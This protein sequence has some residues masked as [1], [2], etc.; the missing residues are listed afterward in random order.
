MTIPVK[1][2][3]LGIDYGSVRL[4]IAVSDPL[5]IIAR[6]VTVLDNSPHLISEIKKLVEELEVDTIVVGF[7]YTLSGTTGKK[8]VE[9]ESFIALLRAQLACPVIT[10]DERFSSK[11]A[12]DTLR[13]MGVAKKKRQRKGTIDEM[14]AALILQSYLDSLKEDAP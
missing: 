6:G 14:A 12:G 11:I 3:V 13:S 9:V 2:R 7:P 10:L 8:G 1:K 5:R 4:G